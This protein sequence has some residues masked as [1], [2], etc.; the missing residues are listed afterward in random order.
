MESGYFN[1]CFYCVEIIVQN[2]FTNL[3]RA[4]LGYASVSSRGPHWN[5][6]DPLEDHAIKKLWTISVKLSLFLVGSG[7]YKRSNA[8]SINPSL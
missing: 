7:F 8:N 6:S 5:L 3:S 2:V 1:G 4:P